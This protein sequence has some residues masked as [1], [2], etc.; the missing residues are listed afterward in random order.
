MTDSNQPSYAPSNTTLILIWILGCLH[1]IYQ[2]FQPNTY[3][4]A[5]VSDHFSYP[6]D[7]VSMTCTWFTF[8]F[9]AQL[10]FR[11]TGATPK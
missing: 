3:P 5:R 6:T 8:Y 2:G 1:I 4:Y 9:I 7:G 11:I 10:F